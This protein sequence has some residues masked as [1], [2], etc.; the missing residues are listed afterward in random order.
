VTI[1]ALSVQLSDLIQQYQEVS[2][3]LASPE[4]L[5]P[6]SYVRSIL[7]SRG[8]LTRDGLATLNN[9]RDRLIDLR[10]FV[11]HEMQIQ[12]KHQKMLVAQVFREIFWDS[13]DLIETGGTRRKGKW[14]DH[15]SIRTLLKPTRRMAVRERADIVK[16]PSAVDEHDNS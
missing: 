9:L 1:D 2:R 10:S 12:N 3:L 7:A 13:D 15:K 8:L 16:I 6:A 14:R 11:E 5:L 4:K